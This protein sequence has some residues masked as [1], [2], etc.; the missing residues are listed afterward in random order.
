MYQYRGC[1]LEN[2]WLINGYEVVKSP[3]GEGVTIH[4]LA[5]LHDAIGKMIVTSPVPLDGAEARFLRQ[6]M[7]FS[8][9]MLAQLVGRDEQTIARW[10]KGQSKKV[11]PA[12]ERL[13]R[14]LYCE[15]KW[16]TSKVKPLVE[17]L[18]KLEAIRPSDRKIIAQENSDNW[19]AITEKAA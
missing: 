11:D 2:V 10:E 17:I 15:S 8:Q 19:T 14:L 12:S 13:I 16:G 4:N 7:E 1:G 3:Y 18:K 6:E 5:E 9:A